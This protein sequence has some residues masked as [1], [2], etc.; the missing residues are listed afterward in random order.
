MN[1]KLTQSGLR[2]DL[3]W[4]DI[5]DHIPMEQLNH[6]LEAKVLNS[7]PLSRTIQ[8]K[9]VIAVAHDGVMEFYCTRCNE[10]TAIEYCYNSMPPYICKECANKQSELDHAMELLGEMKKEINHAS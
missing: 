3:S 9:Q 10:L 1:L 6:L 2:I 5:T 7:L 8:T 4:A